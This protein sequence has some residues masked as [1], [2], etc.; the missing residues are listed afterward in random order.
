MSIATGILDEIIASRTSEIHEA[1]L[2]NPLRQSSSLE[3]RL[4]A[5]IEVLKEARDRIAL[6]EELAGQ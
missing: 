6:A 2:N 4:G 1:A 3:I 5:Q